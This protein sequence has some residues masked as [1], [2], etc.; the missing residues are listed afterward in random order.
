MWTIARRALVV[1][2]ALA[3][4][5]LVA[6]SFCPR[7]D[8]AAV[9]APAGP[10]EA[11]LPAPIFVYPRV[12]DERGSGV[13]ALFWNV[14]H[15]AAEVTV[16]FGD[17]DHPSLAVDR[18]YKLFR[19]RRWRRLMDVETFDYGG[20]PREG[21]AV[22]ATILFPDVFAGDQRWDVLAARHLGAALPIGDFA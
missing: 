10:A 12:D 11:R 18:G 13:V 16:V 6:P 20:L 4:G 22:P 17:E 14:G 8:L 3:L 15:D 21:P 1:L 9:A 2:L 5:V 19:W 7:L